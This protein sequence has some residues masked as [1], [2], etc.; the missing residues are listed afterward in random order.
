MEKLF[1]MDYISQF[2][3]KHVDSPFK[4]IRLGFFTIRRMKLFFPPRN[5][6]ITIEKVHFQWKLHGQIS[7]CG[8]I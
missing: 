5:F 4:C 3:V 7:L 2:R 6:I 8:L 1:H